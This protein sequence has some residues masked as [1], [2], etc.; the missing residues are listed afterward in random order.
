MSTSKRTRSGQRDETNLPNAGRSSAKTRL[1]SN[2][3]SPVL[4]P[5]MPTAARKNRSRKAPVVD[6]QL[7][8]VN[9]ADAVIASLKGAAEA[10]AAHDVAAK[11]DACLYNLGSTRAPGTWRPFELSPCCACLVVNGRRRPPA[12][13]RG[14]AFS[15]GLGARWRP[16]SLP[17][18][19]PRFDARRAHFGHGPCRPAGAAV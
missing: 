11:Y 2:A 10:V 16:G 19:A 17:L 18:G 7:R 1:A 15:R 14:P 8:L 9:I 4:T 12:C 13:S 5:T 6:H 3:R